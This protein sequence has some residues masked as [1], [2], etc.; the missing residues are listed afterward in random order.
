VTARAKGMS[1]WALV[2]KYPVRLAFNPLISTIGWYLPQLFSGSLIVATVMRNAA[3]YLERFFAQ[4]EELKPMTEDVMR[5]LVREKPTLYVDKFALQRPYATPRRSKLD[6]A[7]G[8]FP[9]WSLCAEIKM[10]RIMGDNGIANDNMLMHILSPYPV[11]RSAV[12]DTEKLLASSFAGRKAILIYAYEYPNWPSS[13]AIHAFETL[14]AERARLEPVM[15]ARAPR[16]VRP[17]HS[18]ATVY[19]WYVDQRVAVERA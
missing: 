16:L 9:A 1:E 10:L 17:V 8:A 12:S 2:L 7:F 15:P 11:H 3:N 4:V 5:D 6:I 19:G 14:A 18:S 13:L